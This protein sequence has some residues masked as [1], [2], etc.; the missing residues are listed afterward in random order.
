MVVF[1]KRK[2]AAV[3]CTALLAVAGVVNYN[4]Y[5]GSKTVSLPVPSKEEKYDEN[6]N[7]GEAKY[8]SKDNSVEKN[9]S[10]SEAV[11]LLKSVAE[12]KDA[13]TDKKAEAQGELIRIAKDIE[14]E[15]IVTELLTK[16][17]FSDVAV[18]LNSPQATVSVK[19]EG[20]SQ[21]DLAKIR[22]TLKNDGN[23]QAQ[24][25]KIIEVK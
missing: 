7:Y 21:S 8:V 1:H 10:R 12:S 19:S 14:K 20:L 13:A 23:I 4:Q 16:K 25:L 9:K 18:F 17:G 15:A 6:I 3:L 24:N 11:A 2:I 5:V 22:D